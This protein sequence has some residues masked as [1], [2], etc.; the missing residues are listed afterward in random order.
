METTHRETEKRWGNFSMWQQMLAVGS[1]VGRARSCDDVRDETGKHRALERAL[2]LL[3]FTIADPRWH[4][5]RLRE[6]LRIR[7]LVA[8]QYLNGGEYDARLGDLE[9]YFKPYGYRVGR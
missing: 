7:E 5:H 3:D 4:N 1:E 9:D 2:E 8:D 6:L